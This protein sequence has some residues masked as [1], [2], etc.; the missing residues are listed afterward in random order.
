MSLTDMSLPGPQPPTIIAETGAPASR[1]LTSAFNWVWRSPL[2]LILVLGLLLS[3]GITKGEPFYNN[4]ETRHTMNGVFLRDVL[5][6]R[7]LAHPLTYAYE[8]YA[9]Y[10]AIAVPHWPP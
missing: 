10:P 3:R 2:A 4:D 6:D 5:V 8:Y 7:P 9:K 1:S